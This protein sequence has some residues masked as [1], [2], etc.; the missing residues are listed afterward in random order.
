MQCISCKGVFH[1]DAVDGESSSVQLPRPSCTTETFC[2]A[3]VSVP[4]RAASDALAVKLTFTTPFPVPFAPLVIDIQPRSETAVQEHWLAAETLTEPDP[5]A[6]PKDSEVVE[7]VKVHGPGLG[8][9]GE[10]LP[11][12][13]RAAASG[14]KTENKRSEECVRIHGPPFKAGQQQSRQSLE[15]RCHGD[16]LRNDLPCANFSSHPRKNPRRSAA[17]A[18][19]HGPNFCNQWQAHCCSRSTSAIQTEANHGLFTIRPVPG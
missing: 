11:Q 15:R 17:S 6:A 5:A 14:R 2:P 18:S 9:V 4:V 19:R 12:P 13:L 10:S 1:K 3:M 7:S 16:T 8:E